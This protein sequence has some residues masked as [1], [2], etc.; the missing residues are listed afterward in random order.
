MAIA[1]ARVSIHSRAKGHSAVAAASYRSGTQLTDERTGITYNYSQRQDVL[2]SELLL[3]E[4]VNS[5]FLNRETLW[6]AAEKSEKRRDAQLCKDV[7]LA[8][9]RELSLEL[10]IELTQQFAKTY[11][12]ENG[13]PCDIAIHD[14]GEGNPHAHILIATRRLE[15][16]GFSKYKARDLNPCFAKGM[17]VEGDYWGKR[18]REMQTDFFK[19]KH[20]DLSVDI[21]HI[22]PERHHGRLSN[23]LSYLIEE[24]DLIKTARQEIIITPEKLIEH[25]SNQLSVF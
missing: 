2:F 25:L 7:V 17:V 9:P 19:E 4:G 5:Q 16:N 10:Q 23:T 13:L 15:K 8:L 6:N 14:E 22:I 18:W 20:L 24:K 1:F 21:N 12:I 11:F 3:P